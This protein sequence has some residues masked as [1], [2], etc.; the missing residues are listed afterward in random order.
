M[1]D[2]MH[3]TQRQQPVKTAALV[4]AVMLL[5]VALSATAHS[6]G[7]SSNGMPCAALHLASVSGSMQCVQAASGPERCTT[8]GTMPVR[9]SAFT[10]CAAAPACWRQLDLP[11]PAR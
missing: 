8:C 11:P 10:P 4:A 7:A 2:P 5:S 9:A 1:L 6:V 3:T